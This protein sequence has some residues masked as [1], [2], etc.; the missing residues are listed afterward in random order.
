MPKRSCPCKGQ[1]REQAIRPLQGR[2]IQRFCTV[3]YNPTLLNESASRKNSNS[4]DSN[5]SPCTQTILR[6]R[7]LLSAMASVTGDAP[8][9]AYRLRDPLIRVAHHVNHSASRFLILFVV[10]FKL[11]L[12]MT[13]RALNTERC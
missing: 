2:A 4:S 13:E 6:S 5:F 7:F 1:L 3:G 10:L 11:I 12:N 9:F 8:L